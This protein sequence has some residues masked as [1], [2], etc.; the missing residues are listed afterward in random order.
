MGSQITTIY[1]NYLYKLRTTIP[2]VDWEDRGVGGAHSGKVADVI[3]HSATSNSVCP[4]HNTP[5]LPKS[6][7][8][9]MWRKTCILTQKSWECGPWRTQGLDSLTFQR[10]GLDRGLFASRNNWAVTKDLQN[11]FTWKSTTALRF[12]HFPTSHLGGRCGTSSM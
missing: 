7:S 2:Q 6:K 4:F 12:S 8:G 9:G 1:I 11:I 5:Q 10:L 3:P